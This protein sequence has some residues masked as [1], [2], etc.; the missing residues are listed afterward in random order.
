MKREKIFSFFIVILLGIFI[1]SCEDVFEPPQHNFYG[2]ERIYKDAAFAEGLLL[3]AYNALPSSYNFDE[4]ATDDAVSNVTNSNF[5]RMAIGEWSSQ[6]NPQSAWNSAYQQLYYLNYFLSVVD[7]VE[8]SWESDVRRKL[9]K[10]RFT[11]EARALRAWYNFELLKRHGGLSADGQALGFVIIKPEYT[12]GLD[13]EPLLKLPRDSYENCQQFILDDLNEAISILPEE[14]SDSND[15]LDYNLVYGKQ[16]KNRISGKAVKALKARFLLHIASQEFNKYADKW[17]NA[18]NAAANLILKNGGISGLSSTGVKWY[19]SSKDPDI[20]WRRDYQQINSWEK[21]NFP[22]SQF[23]N[24]QINPSQNLVDAFPMANG[25]PINHAEG[26]YNKNNPYANRDPRLKDYVIY[27]G[28]TINKKVINT[29]VNGTVDGINNIKESTRSGYYLKKL[30]REDVNL[31]PNVN[32]TREHFYTFSRYTEIYLIYA[33]A[34][35]EAWGPDSDPKGY[36][37]TARDVI[38]A[39]RKRAGISQ[40]DNYLSSVASS[41]EG[42]RELIRNERRIELCFEGFRF[43]DIRRWNLDMNVKVKGILISNEGF[44]DI[45]VEDRVYSPHMKFGPIPYEEVLKNANLKQNA[46]W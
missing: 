18:A 26:R 15:N 6:F 44:K 39:I 28:N 19:T 32:T 41:K 43:W 46:G 25:F 16:N 14:Y 17:E 33:E 24:G 10:E 9:F 1:V 22:P 21:D 34:A 29:K 7:K 45:D 40:P 4:T 13:V 12:L 8:W 30:L 38:A 20:I 31:N 11:G 37:F 5:T 27:D 42:L 3:T 35:N 23:G 36:G 2:K